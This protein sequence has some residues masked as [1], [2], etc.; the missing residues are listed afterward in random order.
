MTK[1]TEDVLEIIKMIP[2]GKVMTYGQIAALANS[3]RG[4]RQVSRI[5][6][7][8]SSKHKLP[9]HRVINSKGTISLTGEPGYIQA[10]MLVSEGIDVINKKVDLKKH[11]F[12]LL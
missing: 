5:L 6:H 3:P 4:A 2:R 10:E 9:W 12:K 7:S 8:M 11:L 1:F